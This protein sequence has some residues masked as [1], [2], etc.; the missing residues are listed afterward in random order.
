MMKTLL[1]V[2]LCPASK[3]DLG[4]CGVSAVLGS[5][6]EELVIFQSLREH[7]DELMPTKRGGKKLQ[8]SHILWFPLAN[9]SFNPWWGWYF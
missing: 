9:L 6:R 3:A 2:F 1:Q 7:G 5:M 8:G 4:S